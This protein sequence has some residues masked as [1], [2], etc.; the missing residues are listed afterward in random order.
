[1][2]EAEADEEEEEEE[3][4]EV[5]GVVASV[6]PGSD[7]VWRELREFCETYDDATDDV[8][9]D[10]VEDEDEREFGEWIGT[11]AVRREWEELDRTKPRVGE[12]RL[13]A[14]DGNALTPTSPQ[15]PIAWARSSF[16]N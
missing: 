7:D 11:V 14:M 9:K 8:G 15:F 4:A 13:E 2:T 3:S 6:R 10:E 5:D 1:M 12:E 16:P